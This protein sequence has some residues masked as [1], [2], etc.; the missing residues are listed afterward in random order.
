MKRLTSVFLSF[1]FLSFVIFPVLAQNKTTKPVFFHEGLHE[2]KSAL[3]ATKPGEFRQDKL[4]QFR[5]QLKLK[6]KAI[7]EQ[8]KERRSTIKAKISER[9]KERV[10]RFFSRLIKRFEAAISRLEKLIARIESRLDKIESAKTNTD[11]SSIR[12]ELN[13]AKENLSSARAAIADAKPSLEEIL[14]SDNPKEAF[15]TVRDLIKEVK[16]E[17]IETHRILVHVIGEIRGLRV[18]ATRRG[19]PAPATSA[20]EGE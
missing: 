19:Q 15:G 2:G 10:R 14:A 13:K 5:E 18:G 4:H 7:R 11:T 6:R 8:F 16:T 3:T 9:R 20:A 17:L 12:D 1:V